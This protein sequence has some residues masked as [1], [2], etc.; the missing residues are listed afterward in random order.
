[1]KAWEEI[2][3]KALL[4]SEK[5]SLTSAD[6]PREI[7]EAFDIPD[8]VEKEDAFLKISALAFQFRQS[9]A[10]PINATHITHPESQPETKPYCSAQASLMLK[11]VLEE[12]LLS[13][14]AFWLHVCT[15]KNQLAPPEMLPSLL[16]IATRRKEFRN[17][18]AAVC[19][20]RG[21]WLAQLNTEWNYT[22]IDLNDETVWTEGTA[23]ERKELLRQL[24]IADPER[25]RKLLENAWATEG[26]NEKL[27]FLEILKDTV[28]SVDVPW[29]ESLK[30]KGQK[31]NGA[32]LELLKLIPSSAVVQEYQRVLASVV[33]VKSGKALLGMINKTEIIVDESFAFP[34]SIFKTGIEKLSSDKNISDGKHIVAQLIM[35]VPPSFWQAHLQRTPSEVIELFQ[36][37]KHTSFYLPALAIASAR[38][39]NNEWTKAILDKADVDLIG[40]SIPALLSGMSGNELDKYALKFFNEQPTQIIHLLQRAETEWSIDVAKAVLKFTAREVY[41]YNKQFYRQVIRLIPVSIVGQ[42]DSFTP[43]EEQKKPYWQTQ[44]DE[45]ARLLTLK[46]QILESFNL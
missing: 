19:G 10:Q 23:D 35:A 41:Q 18:V 15:S 37:E 27:A 8:A 26:S 42:L 13:L 32:I 9:G 43:T 1:M 6:L 7:G 45:L 28:S 25:A 12:E 38:F 4:G 22:S 44:R 34:E 24:R 31:V 3:N 5:V 29:L 20:E 2:V 46:Q 33:T 16:N 30:E 14:L 39:R 21:K 17:E 40:N 11:T 36:K